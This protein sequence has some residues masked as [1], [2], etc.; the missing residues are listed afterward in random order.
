[1]FRSTPFNMFLCS[2]AFTDMLLASVVLP[3]YVLSTSIFKHPEGKWGDALCKIMTGYFLAFYLSNVSAYGLVLIALDRLRAIHKLPTTILNSTS[4]RRKVWL[5]IGI[6]WIIPFIPSPG[7]FYFVEYRRTRK[8]LIGN[9]CTVLQEGESSSGGIIFGCVI[10]IIDGLIPL[11]IFIY[12]FSHIRKCL[13]EEETRISETTLEDSINE[14]YKYYN[15]WKMVKRKQKTVQVLMIISAVYVVCWIPNKIMCFMLL[16]GGKHLKLTWVSPAYQIGILIGF[17]GSCINPYLYA[18]QSK[19]FRKHSKRFLKR[20]LPKCLDDDDFEYREIKNTNQRKETS[21][22][23][24]ASEATAGVKTDSN[25]FFT[26]KTQGSETESSRTD[27]HPPVINA[28]FQI[29]YGLRNRI[30]ATY[31]TII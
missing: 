24:T 30:S 6:A 20:L 8:P 12:S 13:V 26:A 15:C 7:T 27:S 10:F 14:G 21:N 28:T 23:S 18:W 9:H 17:T 2:L 4:K 11:V 29:E 1:M 25:T 3:S 5:S 16:G 19:E 22:I 31:E